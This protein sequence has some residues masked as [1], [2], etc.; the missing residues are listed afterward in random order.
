MLD[1]LPHPDDPAFAA[2]FS[3]L[4]EHERE[5]ALAALTA[6]TQ[7]HPRSIP[8]W[9]LL[10]QA[11]HRCTD[12]PACAAAARTLVDLDPRNPDGLHQLAFSLMHLDDYEG[13]VDAYRQAYAVTRSA[14]SGTT[15]ALL[16]HRLGRFDEAAQAYGA[17]LARLAPGSFEALPAFRGAMSLLRD[18]GRPLAA[19]RYAH[20][21]TNAFRLNPGLVG[22]ALVERD[23]ATPFH[24]WLTL[25]GK[26]DL[27]DMLARGLAAEPG[28]RIPESFNLPAQRAAF[29]AFAAAQPAGALYIV[30]PTRGSGGQGI[31]VTA[32]PTQAADRPDAVVQRYI[33][34]PY[35]VDG[36]KGHLRIYA[37]ITSARPLR[38]YIY[39]EGIVRFAPEPY[40]PR[41]ERLGEVSMHVTNTALHLGHPGLVV[42]QD[43]ERDDEGAIWSVSALLRRMAA[44]GFDPEAVF[45]EISDLIGWFLRQLDREGLFARQADRAPPRGFGPK[46]IG[47]DILLDADGHPWLIEMQSTPAASGAPLVVRINGGLFANIFRMSVGV[48]TLDSMSDAQLH[49]I[50]RDPAA[51]AQAEFDLE[52]RHIGGFKPLPV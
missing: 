39:S 48:F 23:Q 10:A 41:P 26:A 38:A 34:N 11:H 7:A 28:A 30:K 27:G 13:A 8:A 5:R 45:G 37:L 17:V 35:L 51:L 14:I 40:D 52:R 15:H 46:L 6:L 24:E 1:G 12:I 18:S 43:P 32:D 21:L 25:V 2:T 16:L 9:T 33:A 19:D 29:L 22:S 44:D 31:F 36:R 4:I 20:M 49:T 50:R 3:A 47:F 42:S